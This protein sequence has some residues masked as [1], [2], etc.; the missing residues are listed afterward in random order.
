VL[1]VVSAVSAISAAPAVAQYPD[2]RIIPR[3]VLRIGFEPE[4]VTYDQR[5]GPNG[6]VEL[7]GKDFT[8]DSAGAD[9]LPSLVEPQ[10]AVRDIVGADDY[11]MTLGSITTTLDADI[12]KLGFNFHLGLTDRLTLTA[13]IPFVTARIQADVVNDSTSA[14]AGLNRGGDAS[15]AAAIQALLSELESGAAFVE[16]EIA[17]NSYGCPTSALCDQARDLVMRTRLLAADLGSVMGF[18]SGGPAADGVAPF[19]PLQSS[20]E[21]QAILSAIQSIAAELQSFNATPPSASLPLPTERADAG[22]FQSVL[23][24]P[25]FGYGATGGIEFIKYRQRLGDAELGVRWGAVQRPSLRAV[26][27][28][29]VRLPTG[30]RDDPDHYIDLGTGDRQ[31]DLSGGLEAVWM[32][33]TAVALAVNAS[34]TAQLGDKLVRRVAPPH[35][36][37]APLSRRATVSRNLGDFFVAGLYPSVRLTEGFTAYGSVR[38]FRKGVDRFSVVNPPEAAVPAPASNLLE[39]ETAM[40]SWSFGGGVHYYSTGRGGTALPL[41]AGID[42]RAAFSGSGGLTPKD[43]RVYFYLRLY[44]RVF[45]GEEGGTAEGQ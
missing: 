39:Q 19:V 34:Y 45:G 5:F 43:V 41:Q 7:L 25:E 11:R 1:A 12:R 42:Y 29:S 15:A 14:N 33:G 16:R 37:I 27:R 10:Q 26:L 8:S 31:T 30:M 2:A 21:G 23:T 40:R 20:A 35:Q 24:A 17:A 28:G 3:G 32:P 9:L 18:T 6:E 44:R 22:A 36:P 38:Y 13:S 4:Y